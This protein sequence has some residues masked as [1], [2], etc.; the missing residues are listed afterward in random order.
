MPAVSV[1]KSVDQHQLVMKTYGD[2]VRGQDVAIDTKLGVVEQLAQ[3]CGNLLP[4][5]ADI[6]ARL[7][8]G[9]RSFPGLAEHAFVQIAAEAL[10][11]HRRSPPAFEPFQ[12]AQNVGLLP[13][14]KLPLRG[15]VS[16]NE[17]RGFVW[18]E[19]RLT[20]LVFER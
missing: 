20:R 9:A 18:I 17:L 5:A 6:L 10:R 1:R 13:F 11:K 19:R 3:S 15:D 14:I 12:R 2:F 4:V 8:K 7:T 16:G